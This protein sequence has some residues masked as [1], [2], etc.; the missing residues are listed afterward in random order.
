MGPFVRYAICALKE[1]HLQVL[2]LSAQ[3]PTLLCD[4]MDL[5]TNWLCTIQSCVPA[6]WPSC[7]HASDSYVSIFVLIRV[8]SYLLPPNS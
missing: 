3:V 2:D 5:M 6:V 7:G 8:R 4:P 1:V